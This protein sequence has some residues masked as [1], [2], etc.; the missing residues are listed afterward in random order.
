MTRSF[1][2]F[3][4]DQGFQADACKSCVD[5]DF[6]N[7]AERMFEAL[8]TIADP[9]TAALTYYGTVLAMRG[10]AKMAMRGG[11]V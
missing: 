8:E 1:H 11:G 5:P 2:R 4:E 6:Y 9:T 10:H 7:L 3:L